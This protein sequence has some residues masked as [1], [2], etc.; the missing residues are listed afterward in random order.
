[1]LLVY[2]DDIVIYSETVDEHLERLDFVFTRLQEHGLKLRPK[3][4]HF[5]KQEISYLG[6]IVSVEGVFTLPEKIRVV[7]EW[8]SPQSVKDLRSFLGFSS[9]Y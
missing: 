1:M 6:Y 3:K 4:C 9:Y 8:P 2:L 5:F 7:R